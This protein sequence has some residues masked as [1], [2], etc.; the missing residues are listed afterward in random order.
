MKNQFTA[1]IERGEKYLIA[2]CPEVPEA[3]G[4]G[5]SREACLRD[6]SASIESVLDY[7]R[8]EAL[9]NLHADAEKA[10]VEVA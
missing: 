5:L 8:E 2:T 6:L 7:R 9:A 10:V 3:H 1:I 4:Q